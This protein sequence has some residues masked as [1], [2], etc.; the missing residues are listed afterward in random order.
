MDEEN[1]DFIQK[2]NYSNS[3]WENTDVLYQHSKQRFDEFL[4]ISDLY[5]N[6]LIH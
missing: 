6:Y 1:L 5:I 2:F 3:F 4:N